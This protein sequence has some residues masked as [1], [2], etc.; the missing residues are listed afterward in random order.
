[1]ESREEEGV[2]PRHVFIVG[3]M[4]IITA[5]A[6]ARSAILQ[7][8]YVRGKKSAPLIIIERGG[9]ARAA[10]LLHTPCRGPTKGGRG[11]RA[12]GG[13]SDDFETDFH[14]AGATSAS[15]RCS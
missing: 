12:R 3:K 15:Y 8:H 10:A 5:W 1:M 9:R 2:A 7:I 11:S 6:A 13:T 14:R 4:W